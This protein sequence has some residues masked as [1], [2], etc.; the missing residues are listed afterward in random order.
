[1]RWLYLLIDLVSLSIPLLY[2][3]H[4]KIQF[5]REWKA[6]LAAITGTALLFLPWD[7]AFTS[8]GVWGFNARY[9]VG[10]RV[11]DLP[12]EEI[13]F[14]LCIPYSCLF[15]YFCLQKLLSRTT[16]C[17]VYAGSKL[18]I[19]LF[20][21]LAV[22][23]HSAVYTLTAS[24]CAALLLTIAHVASEARVLRDFYRAYLVLLVP[25]FIVN[26]LLTGTGI[27]DEVVWYND[28]E[29]LGIRILTIPLDDFIYGF[30]MILM[31]VLIFETLRSRRSA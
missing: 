1:M 18:L 2:S 17:S 20:V 27:P 9:V 13:L 11:A 16:E 19:A 29:N 21:C 6:C 10:I 22:F 4:P 8:M 31:N 24:L 14:F 7:A 26:G 25:F 5:Y 3:F 15:T 12:I 28:S 30:A 23:Y